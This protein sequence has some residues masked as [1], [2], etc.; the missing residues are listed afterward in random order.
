MDTENSVTYTQFQ[1]TWTNLPVPVAFFFSLDRLDL[2]DPLKVWPPGKLTYRGCL[3]L[4]FTF[5]TFIKGVMP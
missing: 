3:F 1:L 5:G 2:S 4:L